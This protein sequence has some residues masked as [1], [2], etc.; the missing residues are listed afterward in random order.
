EPAPMARDLREFVA[1][2]GVSVVGGCCGTTPMHIAALVEALR[3]VTP[4]ARSPRIEPFLASSMRAVG[5]VQD[6][7]PTLIGERVNTQGSRR[8][9]RLLLADDYDGVLDVARDQVEGGAH[10]LDVCVALTE[11]GD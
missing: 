2:Y 4:H 10:L 6:P 8:V 9:K 7:P 11:R 1:E 3:G 5:M